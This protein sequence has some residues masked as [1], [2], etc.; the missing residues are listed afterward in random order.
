M[1]IRT[2]PTLSNDD[3]V[4]LNFVKQP[5]P[6]YFRTHYREGLRSRLLQV[7]RPEDILNETQGTIDQG[8][9]LF[10][11]AQPVAMLR[12]FKKQ[13]STWQEVQTEI[14]NYKLVQH[15]IPP[16]HYAASSEF[17]VDYFQN[18]NSQ[19]MLCGLQEYIPGEAVDPWHADT[20]LKLETDMNNSP[21]GT[22]D[23]ALLNL[24]SFIGCIKTMAHQVQAIP[25]LAGVGNLILTPEA[26]IK[27]VDINNISRFSYETTIPLDDKN[28]PVSDKSIQALYNLETLVLGNDHASEEKL[29]RFFIN[30]KRVQTVRDLE[31][32]F[33]K[34]TVQS[35][36]YPA[37][38]AK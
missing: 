32:A 26:E 11:V 3:I 37:V 22:L 19:I 13:F 35:G 10:P 28:Y 18:E 7:L 2:K 20:R 8:A 21:N 17:I 1:D 15:Y 24:A 16:H 14:E 31:I 34:K 9:R 33:Q 30:R 4:N 23:L 25:D 5:C 36:N 12:I 27:L 29:Y 38:K 6:Y